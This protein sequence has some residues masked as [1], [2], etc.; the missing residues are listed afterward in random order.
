MSEMGYETVP[1]RCGAPLKADIAQ[2]PSR[3]ISGCEQ[4]QQ[5]AE[6]F[7]HLSAS[8]PK[9]TSGCGV[10]GVNDVVNRDRPVDAFERQFANRFDGRYT[11]DLHQDPRANQDLPG[12]GFVAKPRALDTVPMEA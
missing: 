2:R 9:P 12:L 7:D 11:F 4:M 3:A 6:L 8:P 10:T 5:T 1:H